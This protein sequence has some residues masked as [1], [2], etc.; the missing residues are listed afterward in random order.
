[1]KTRTHP[2]RL[3]LIALAAFGFAA[4]LTAMATERTCE[5]CRIEYYNCLAPI[6]LDADRCNHQY[7]QCSVMLECPIS[8]L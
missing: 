4:S 7:V 5:D 8:N 2:S 1:M 6:P 3:A